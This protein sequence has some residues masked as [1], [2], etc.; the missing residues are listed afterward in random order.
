M[1]LYDE[2]RILQ[3]RE[4]LRVISDGTGP[5][6]PPLHVRI[7]PTESCNFKCDFCIFHGEERSK[8]VANTIDF[9]GKR[10]LSL[11][12]FLTLID[13]L[14]EI[15]T[16]AVSFTGAGDPM[17]YPDMGPVLERVR[18]RG[19]H[20]G[21]TS[22]LAM[23]INDFAIEQLAQVKWIRWSMN[24][25]TQETYVQVHTIRKADGEKVFTRAQE[26]VR[27][28]NAI[29]KQVAEPA[30][31]NA[32]FVV[33]NINH[34]DILAGARLAASLGVDSIAFRPDIEAAEE[35]KDSA[36]QYLRNV[37]SDI[38]KAATESNGSGLAIHVGEERLE[39]VRKLDDEDLVCF[40]ANHSTY[41]A[42]NGDVYPCCY[43]RQDKK[44]VIG[45]ILS[46][47]FREFWETKERREAY[48]RL[49]YNLCPSCPYGETN[50]VLSS[51]YSGAASVEQMHREVAKPD[52]FV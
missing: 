48:R 47:S 4:T 31:F 20:A 43:T 17:V 25:G 8:S 9:T 42:A 35:R 36:A 18:M 34:G 7:E 12:R 26:N 41:I 14:A 16:K 6:S 40:Y 1:G 52:Y 49:N 29:R 30:T 27:R 13:E 45:N 19:M 21:V 10:R 32:S 24:A 11:D 37:R 3:H 46:Q 15:G 39:D 44:Y 33:S 2:I 38:E 22:N 28:I 5:S 50:Q 51:L 23:P